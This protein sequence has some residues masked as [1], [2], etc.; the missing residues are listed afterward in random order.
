MTT[1]QFDY[2]ANDEGAG[3]WRRFVIEGKGHVKTQLADLDAPRPEQR[4]PKCCLAP[5]S[6]CYA[7]LSDHRETKAFIEFLVGHRGGSVLGGTRMSAVGDG[8]LDLAPT[9][10]ED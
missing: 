1:L 2:I 6:K 10:P 3:Y 8:D 4:A 5:H 9:G 7:R